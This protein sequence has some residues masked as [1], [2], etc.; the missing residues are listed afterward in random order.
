MGT[1]ASVAVADHVK[2]NVNDRSIPGKP[3]YYVL[4]EGVAVV[5]V[6]AAA[7]SAFAAGAS[8]LLTSPAGFAAPSAG[9]AVSSAFFFEALA[10]E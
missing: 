5:V 9:L 1:S 10:D 6:A 3:G 8:G 7:G 4:V 2:V